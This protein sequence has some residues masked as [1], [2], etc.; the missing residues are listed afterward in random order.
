[1]LYFCDF[2]ISS[3]N[4]AIGWNTDRMLLILECVT[5]TWTIYWSFNSV[6]PIRMCMQTIQPNRRENV[7][8]H[9]H[10]NWFPEMQQWPSTVLKKFVLT[11]TFW[12]MVLFTCQNMTTKRG[13]K[14]QAV[15]MYRQNIYYTVINGTFIT[16]FSRQ[17]FL[18]DG[19]QEVTNVIEHS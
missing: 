10:L 6:L 11:V 9:H 18:Q 8:A 15:L 19:A 7:D 3:S 2:Q 4:G 5:R 16:V 12:Q 13:N 14:V 1:M 17:K